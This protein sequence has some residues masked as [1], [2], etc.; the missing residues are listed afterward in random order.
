MLNAASVLPHL[1]CHLP[2]LLDIIAI[3]PLGGLTL[4]LAMTQDALALITLHLRLCHILSSTLCRW[5]MTSLGG[6]WN[7]FR[8]E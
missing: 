3:A 4:L 2:A 1:S 6:L 8:G 7:L 5:Q